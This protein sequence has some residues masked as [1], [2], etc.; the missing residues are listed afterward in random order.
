MSL[1]AAATLLLVADG[2]V[3]IVSGPEQPCTF[4]YEEL[5]TGDDRG[6]MDELQSCDAATASDPAIQIN[7]GVA[8][9]RVG[10]FDAA[11]SSFEA[12]ARNAERYELETATGNWV[13]SRVLARR[14]LAMLDDGAFRGYE[15]LA[16]R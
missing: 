14:G 4:G 6:A 2:S 8:L 11:R 5:A 15:A 12:A 7:H 9:A 10:E 16:V 1:L 13:D 3:V